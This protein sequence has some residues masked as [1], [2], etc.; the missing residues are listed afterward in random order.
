MCRRF[1]LL[2]WA[3]GSAIPSEQGILK[4][5]PVCAVL[6]PNLF[7]KLN[8][9]RRNSPT[10]QGIFLPRAGNFSDQ[11]GNSAGAPNEAEK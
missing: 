11:A 7:R 6:V 5:S 3:R 9:Q 8:T 1:A 2:C 10:E 4:I